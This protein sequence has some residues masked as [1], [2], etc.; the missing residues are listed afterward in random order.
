VASRRHFLCLD[1]RQSSLFPSL[2]YSGAEMPLID[3]EQIRETL[4]HC[5]PSIEFQS[6]V[7]PS[8]QRLVF[9]CSFCK[10]TDPGSQEQ[11]SEWGTVVVKVSEDVHATVIARLE[12][13]RE[14]LNGLHSSYFPRLLHSDV[15]SSDPVTEQRFR[16]RLFITIEECIDGTNLDACG[17]RFASEE[18]CVLLLS[19]LVEGLQLLWNHQHRLIYRDLKPENII[20]R[21]DGTPVIIDL[22]IVREEGTAGLTA[23]HQDIGPCTPHYASPEQL[24]NEKRFITFKSD[25]FSLG[26][27]AYELLT[28]ANPFLREA[29]E[30]LSALVNRVLTYDPPPLVSS[31]KVSSRLSSLIGRLMAKQPYMRPRTV[32]DLLQELNAIRA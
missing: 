25:L 7:K 19:S 12:K 1:Y 26:V 29:S 14:I 2:V 31:G 22:G 3:S 18:A 15:F 16:H 5:F 21:A 8:G 4:Q 9:F 17:S 27:I 10:N 13:E 11:W 20:I 23:T 32:A 6:S 28:G 24:R 30:P